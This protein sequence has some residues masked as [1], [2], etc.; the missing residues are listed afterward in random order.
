MRMKTR[1]WYSVS[2]NNAPTIFDQGGM[3]TAVGA[4]GGPA[5]IAVGADYN[6]VI[7][8][9]NGHTYHGG[10]VSV[11]CG[12]YPTIVELHGEVGYT[13]VRGF[14][15]YDKAIQIVDFLARIGSK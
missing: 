12:L 8:N 10:T 15:V 3:G 9:K 4:S 6:M 2:G 13:W 14:N 7:D 11:T 5:V 1:G